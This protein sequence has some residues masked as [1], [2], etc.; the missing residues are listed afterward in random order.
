MLLAFFT[1]LTFALVVQKQWEVNKTTGALK[2]IKAVAPN[3]ISNHC[4]HHSHAFSV[5]AYFFNF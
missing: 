1:E 5:I 3:Y 4:I 2:Q